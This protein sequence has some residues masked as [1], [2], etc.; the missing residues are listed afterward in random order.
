MK[1]EPTDLENVTQVMKEF[2]NELDNLGVLIDPGFGE[3]IRLLIKDLVAFHFAEDRNEVTKLM[4][5][6]GIVGQKLKGL[7]NKWKSFPR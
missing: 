5:D 6:L 7:K 4:E 1:Q 2:F 3:R